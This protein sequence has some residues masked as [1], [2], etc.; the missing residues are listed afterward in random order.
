[1]EFVAPAS[2]Q[3]ASHMV[4]DGSWYQSG[5]S[6][7]DRAVPAFLHRAECCPQSLSFQILS[8]WKTEDVV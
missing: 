7:F 4:Q 2:N 5:L 6:L 1:M 3:V 8:G